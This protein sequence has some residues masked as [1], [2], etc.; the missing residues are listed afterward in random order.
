MVIS[1][2]A[3]IAGLIHFYY[4]Q[5]AQ[6]LMG[7]G[8]LSL[9]PVLIGTCWIFYCLLRDL[10]RYI[11]KT[12]N[13]PAFRSLIVPS[14]LI[15]I[16]NVMV[17]MAGNRANYLIEESKKN[18]D[19]VIEQ[20]TQ[21]KMKFGS[22]P[23]DLDQLKEAGFFVKG[24]ELKNSTFHYGLTETGPVL[25]F[26]SLAYSLCSRSTSNPVWTCVD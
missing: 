20:V 9:I 22:Y 13:T 21:Y 5:E 12:K 15:L 25:S 2:I 6:A 4:A 19:H 11:K 23:K 26:N 18:G 3:L 10:L 1:I 14:I 17:V 24:P 16:A 7:I 8:S